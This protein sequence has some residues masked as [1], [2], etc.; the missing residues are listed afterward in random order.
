MTAGKRKWR[1]DLPALALL[2]LVLAVSLMVRI[3]LLDAPL[4]RDE[5][6]HAYMAQTMLQGHPPWQLAYNMKLPGTDAMYALFMAVFG[7][8]AVAIRLGLLLVNTATILLI[9]LF[10]KRLFGMTGGAVAGASYGI[11]SFSQNVFGTI[12][13]ST[14]F[15]VFFAVIASLVLVKPGATEGRLFIAGL[16]Y[17]L[18]F[19]MKQPGICFAVCGA[20]YVAWDSR[21]HRLFKRLAA[22]GIGVVLPYLLLCLALWKAGVFGRFWFWTVTLSGAYVSQF[23]L[24][25]RVEYFKLS[26]GNVVGPNLFL[27]ILAGLGVSMACWNPATRRAGLWIAALL[28]FS[29]LAVALGGVFNPH[30]Y[31]LMFPAL[32]LAIGASAASERA[33]IWLFGLACLYSM[34]SQRAYLFH[35][36]PYE[37]SSATYGLNPFPEAVEIADY[38]RSHS[39]PH[40]RI[41]V[42]GSEAEIY[43][44]AR[45]QAAT[46]YLFTYGL[47]E[48]HRYAERSQGEMIGEILASRPEYIV[49]A[50]VPTSWLARPNSSQAIFYWLKDYLQQY[51][52]VGAVEIRRG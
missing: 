9:A 52:T 22:F 20:L 2:A 5:G 1:G 26:I 35:M 33:L 45:R 7:Q 39:D 38:I 49:F 43:F 27:W 14:H 10:G 19:L 47:M 28:P 13:H 4:E 48:T 23:S 8:T 16:I 51:E 31:I 41:A 3:R 29:F 32:A 11:L 12:A 18:A 17:G 6:E 42:L 34:Y 15:V 40:A 25:L 21:R 46:G 36:T 37:F 44:Y 24:L 30:Y 50:G